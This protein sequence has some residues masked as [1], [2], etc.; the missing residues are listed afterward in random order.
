MKAIDELLSY[1]GAIMRREADYLS[2]VDVSRRIP[3][4]WTTDHLD[5]RHRLSAA[6]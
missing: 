5:R 3:S 4:A 2:T 6:R 1:Y